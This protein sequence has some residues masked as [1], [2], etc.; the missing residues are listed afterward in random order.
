MTQFYIQEPP[1]Q[2]P[3][4]F[5]FPEM[6]RVPLLLLAFACAVWGNVAVFTFTS[7]LFKP[8]FFFQDS[9]PVSQ[10]DFSSLYSFLSKWPQTTKQ[11]HETTIYSSPAL[12][13]PLRRPEQGLAASE[14][15]ERFHFLPL[16]ASRGS[17]CFLAC[18]CV[19]G[20]FASFSHLCVQVFSSEVSQES[21]HLGLACV[22]QDVLVS[23]SLLISAKTPYLKK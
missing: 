5:L 8:L 4:N 1:A 11:L 13:P 7:C 18:D 9:V 19:T 3:S 12:L 6:R 15:L 2:L 21:L 23:R 14:S 22:I 17:G 20:I 10:W 16:P